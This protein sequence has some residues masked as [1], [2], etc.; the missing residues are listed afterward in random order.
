[1]KGKQLIPLFNTCLYNFQ[2]ETINK[3]QQSK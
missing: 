1:M 2:N 3:F